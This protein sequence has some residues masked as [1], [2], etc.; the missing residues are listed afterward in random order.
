MP[1][2]ACGE[3]GLKQN[4]WTLTLMAITAPYQPQS[5]NLENESKIEGL[6]N[7]LGLE[8]IVKLLEYLASEAV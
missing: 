2:L 7:F 5:S 1:S 3:E 8:G 4:V 6:P